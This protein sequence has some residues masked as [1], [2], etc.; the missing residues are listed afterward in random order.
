MASEGYAAT[1]ELYD[2]VVPYRDRPDIHFFVDLA[3]ESGGPVLELGCGTGRVLIP[4]SRAGVQIV[5]LD[6]SPEMLAVCRENV[7]EEPP[8]VQAR[9]RLVEGDMR[10]FELSRQFALVTIPFRPFQHLLDVDD[11]LACLSCVHRHLENDGKLVLDV[12]NPSLTS[13][14]RENL[15]QEQESAPP[16]A[17]PDGRS[18]VRR[19]KVVARDYFR[20]IISI[21]LIYYVTWPDGREERLVHALPM[22]YFFRYELE[23]LLERAGFKMEEAYADYERNPYGSTYP[24]ELVFVARKP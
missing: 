1:A 5:G 9:I 22:R 18:V 2:F 20:Q 15:D 17:L 12:F 21:E 16:F 13:L 7:Q 6:Q 3:R 24:G 10:Q 14:T 23:H 4:T 19:E 11:Q 8:D